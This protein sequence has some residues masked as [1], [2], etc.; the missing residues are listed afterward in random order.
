[1]WS[2]RARVAL[3]LPKLLSSPRSN[4]LK[5][6]YWTSGLRAVSKEGGSLVHRGLLYNPPSRRHVIQ[7]STLPSSVEPRENSVLL[8]ILREPLG[9]VRRCYCLGD[10]RVTRPT[11]HPIA[12]RKALKALT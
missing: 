2:D 12:P 8:N 10:H 9:E 6:D 11:L 1:M 5:P 7:K 3:L 4:G